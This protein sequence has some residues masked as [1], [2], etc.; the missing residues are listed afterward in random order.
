LPDDQLRGLKLLPTL[1]VSDRQHPLASQPHIA[2]K[3]L[4]K[5]LATLMRRE[6][7]NRALQ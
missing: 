5:Q 4:A 6:L 3:P 2:V 1:W 7:A